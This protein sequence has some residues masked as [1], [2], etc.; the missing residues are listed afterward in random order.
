MAV[1]NDMKITD[2]VKFLDKIPYLDL[3]NIT[4]KCDIG[5]LVIKKYGISNQ[6]ALPNK[7]FE[8]ALSGLPI[9]SSKLNNVVRV[10]KKYNLGIVVEETDINEQKRA[11]KKIQQL[12][13]NID[14]KIIKRKF[15]WPVQHNL[16][17]D[18]VNGK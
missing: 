2:R 13:F 15:T 18:T 4:H 11:I 5:W 10:I 7:L 9:I 6:L 3:L 17:I 12:N 14:K 1:V 8:Y 16:F